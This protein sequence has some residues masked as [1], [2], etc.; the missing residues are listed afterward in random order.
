M[1]DDEF[2]SPLELLKRAKELVLDGNDP[3]SHDDWLKVMN[4]FAYNISPDVV[5]PAC[6]LL[7]EIFQ[8]PLSN[9]EVMA[10]VAFQQTQKIMEN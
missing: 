9:A 4:V 8:M 7:V 10:I 6:M 2:I 5:L 3:Q 1:E